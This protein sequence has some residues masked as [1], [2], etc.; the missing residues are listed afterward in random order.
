MKIMK[1]IYQFLLLAA[2]CAA[3][4]TACSDDDD[5]YLVRETDSIRFASCLASSK[6]ITLRCNGSWRTVIPEDAGW[7][8][9]SPSE[10]VGSGAFE[11]IA[12]SATHNRS[13][14]R[15]AT[16][17]LESGGRQYPITVT[18]ADGAVV[19]GAPYVE[20][21]LIEQEPSKSRLCFTYANA[22]GDETIDV[23]CTLSGDSQGLSVAGAS[24]SLVNGGATVAL[25]IAGTPTVPGYGSPTG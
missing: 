1:R 15:T 18:Q 14:E 16:I 10:G 24:V 3:L 6:Q 12:V 2:G 8:S 13:A 25:D 21:N 17:Y 20:G 9:T 11:W 19:Y 7:L 4:T 23:S 5:S 22:Y